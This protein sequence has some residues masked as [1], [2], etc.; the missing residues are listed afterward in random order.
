VTEAILNVLLVDDDPE[1]VGDFKSLLPSNMR[2]ESVTGVEQARACLKANEVDVVFLDIDLGSGGNGLKFLK[3]LK[4]KFPYL[5]VVMITADRKVDSVVKAIRLG[6]SDYVGKSPDLNTLKL[7]V[8]RAISENRLQQRCDLL[9]SELDEMIGDLIGESQAM[10]KIKREMKRLA[11]VSSSVLITGYSGTGKELVARGIH[12]LSPR[13]NQPFVAVNC[14]ALS[15]ELIESELFGHEKGAFTGALERRLGK[16][17]LVGSGTL[18]LDEITEIPLEVQAK[19]LRVLQECEFER[20]GGS[21]MIQF[22]GRILASSNRDID[23]AVANG[24]LRQDL[25]YRLDVTRIHLPPLSERKDD[26]PL[27]VDYFV[28]LKA[29]E[30]KKKVSSASDEALRLLCSCNWPGNVRELANR[31]ENAMVHADNRILGMPDF[32]RLIM[33]EGF[34]DGYEE[35]KKRCLA[36]FQRNY[37]SVLLKKNGGNV[38]KTAKEMGVTRQG[39]AKMMN[40]CGLSQ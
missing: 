1:F 18:F 11:E 7:S 31:I 24:K 21:R 25:L 34:S 40:G 19:F 5:P 23:K 26:I 37:I 16:F 38:T 9:E 8:D 30:M 12:R 29:K 39:L 35:A 2:C 17:E 20:V 14:A 6:A 27:L 10:L 36:E 13:R 22:E 3:Q 15:R 33:N 32:R 28:H 4:S